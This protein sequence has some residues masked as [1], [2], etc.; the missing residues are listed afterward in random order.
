M[1]TSLVSVVYLSMGA[2][3]GA[4]IRFLV[5]KP[6]GPTGIVIINIIASMILAKLTTFSLSAENKIMLLTGFCG[7]LS[8]FS[9]YVVDMIKYYQ[10]NNYL[11]LI[12]YFLASNILSVLGAVYLK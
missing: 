11:A 4:L 7:S 5:S 10:N 12:V 9:T 1:L 8:T 3:V 6:L 2:I